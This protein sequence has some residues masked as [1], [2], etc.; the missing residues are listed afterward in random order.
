MDIT[1]LVVSILV[2]ALCGILLWAL[3]K[4]RTNAAS[5]WAQVVKIAQGIDSLPVSGPLLDLLRSRKFLT[6]VVSFVVYATVAVRP[7][8]AAVQGSL[9]TFLLVGA[10]FLAGF[11]TIEDVANAKYSTDNPTSSAV[12][13]LGKMGKD[14]VG[15][16]AGSIEVPPV[17]SA[18]TP[19]TVQVKASQ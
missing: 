16:L 17:N 14:V 15:A 19:T 9:F 7:D 1:L 10:L 2:I 5:I 4:G 12:D 3:A 8:M 18:S 11:I 6:L 13:A